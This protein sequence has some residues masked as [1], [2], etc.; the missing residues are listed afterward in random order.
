M[1]VYV[2]AACEKND[3]EPETETNP[4]IFELVESTP[5][6]QTGLINRVD[7]DS[8]GGVHMAYTVIKDNITS[9]KY[10][11]K[12][13]NGNWIT[14]EICPSL[15][16][17]EID[18]AIDPNDNVYIAFEPES[19]EIV[20]LAI[21]NQA[22]TFDDIV[23]DVLGDANHQ[24][25]YPALFA[26]R[27]GVIHITLDRANYGLRYTSYTPGSGFSVA[28]TLTDQYSG[29]V[30]DLVID[31]AGNIHIA[32]ADDDLIL[33]AYSEVSTSD[34]VISEIYQTV[35]GSQSYEGINLVMDQL[36][37]LHGTFRNGDGDNNVMYMRYVPGDVNWQIQ[38]IG[39]GGGG[40]NRTDRA[41][42]CD[43]NNIPHILYDQDFALQMATLN[44][45]WQYEFILGNTD[46]RCDVNYDIQ[47][48]HNN[49]AHVSF[50]NRT[51]DALYYATRVIE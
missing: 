10:A 45:D 18:L 49:R 11:H 22:G 7:Y 35:S 17:S 28:E 6:S 36:G 42:A 14:Q 12:P 32:Y 40:S 20:H 50:Y 3:P 29:S 23:V 37:N 8:K 15:W 25:R 46:N 31:D 38:T 30:S 13:L 43:M 2:L 19:D 44:G 48:D 34:W 26:D 24:G 27:N 5:E 51:E 21:K 1:A 39:N 41:I 47:I 4:W 16:Y 33:Y 9:L